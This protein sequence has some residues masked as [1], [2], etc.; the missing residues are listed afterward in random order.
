M[1]HY[2]EVRERLLADQSQVVD[3][4][5]SWLQLDEEVEV[6]WTDAQGKPHLAVGQFQ[7]I[8][9]PHEGGPI[10]FVLK[11]G[12]E[13]ISLDPEDVV[14]MTKREREPLG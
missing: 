1:S 5:E 4:P 13:D 6:V 8:A 12:D 2:Q 11:N 10:R 9:V 7:G 3:D 14:G